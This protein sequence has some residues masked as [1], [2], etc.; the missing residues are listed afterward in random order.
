ME[1]VFIKVFYHHLS[2]MQVTTFLE[3]IY[4]TFE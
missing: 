2:L 3:K 4:M 1:Y